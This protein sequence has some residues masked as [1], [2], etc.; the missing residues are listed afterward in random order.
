MA[1]HSTANDS[2]L[3]TGLEVALPTRR[4][5]LAVVGAMGGLV[6]A[7]AGGAIFVAGPLGLIASMVVGSVLLVTLGSSRH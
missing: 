2:A 4:A 6:G 3:G 5:R 1:R 7:L